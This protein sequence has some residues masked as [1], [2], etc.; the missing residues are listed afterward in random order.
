[1]NFITPWL[2]AIAAAIAIPSLI[3]LYF[4]KLRRRDLEVSTTLLWKKAVQDL[5]ANAPFQRLRRNILLF[6]QLLVLAAV[7]FALA[8]PMIK[9][10]ALS[11]ERFVILIDRSASMSSEDVEGPGGAAA[12]K[13]S[14]LD[15]AKRQAIA[16]VDSLKEGDALFGQ[17]RGD[18]AK[19]IVFDNTA[20]SLQ[21][22]TNDKRKLKDV[23]ESI[24]PTDKVSSIADEQRSGIVEAVRLALADLPRRKVSDAVTDPDGNVLGNETISVEGLYESTVAM[25][26]FSDGKLLGSSQAR[27]GIE[28]SVEY[29]AIG[30][31]AAKNLAIITLKAERD[32]EQPT[33]VTIFVGLQ[34]TDEQPR[35]VD[36]ELL[37]DGVTAQ[38]QPAQMP[39][40]SVSQGA[41][42]SEAAR[43]GAITNQQSEQVVA[44]RIRRP[45]T[46]GVTFRLDRSQG[47][48]AQVRLRQPGTGERP[49]DDAL[50]VDDR[51]WLVV[52]PAQRMSVAI[53]GR[54]NLFL[55]LALEGLPLARFDRFSVTEFE[56][57][58][59]QGRAGAYDV[60]ILDGPIPNVGQQIIATS[61]PSPAGP[62]A[63]PGAAGSTPTA[64]AGTGTN[65][66]A[67]AQRPLPPG[68]YLVFGTVPAG[69][70]L[71]DK[72]LM[73][74]PATVIDW[75]REHPAT[76]NL[77]LDSLQIAQFREVLVDPASGVTKI[78][79][80]ERGPAILEVAKAD[81][82]AIIVPFDYMESTWP[83]DLSF[84]VFV[85]STVKYLGEEV[86]GQ[87]DARAL[88][89]GGELQDTLPIGV[90]EARIDGPGELRATVRPAADGAIVYRIP[91][92]TGVYE[93]TWE[94]A[95]APGDVREGGGE[96]GR[97]LRIF[98]ANLLDQQ[99]SDVPTAQQLE[100]A[101][102]VE[103]AA[104]SAT[105]KG[106]RRLWP[107]LILLGL[108]VV[109]L[110]WFIY[111][112]KVY[113]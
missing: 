26:I 4:L 65:T 44:T 105:G 62:P 32:Y 36:V 83:L 86:G 49:A 95:A 70:G 110:E 27:P 24:Q 43:A 74:Q 75:S 58:W 76:R 19:V 93:V 12:P 67:G 113:V 100:L 80:A 14:R 41:D 89:P 91:P 21:T 57:L 66:P 87:Y 17:S 54:E 90:T 34:N 72:G 48:L 35:T 29:H 51:A 16:L 107:Y 84:V 20:E 94:G 78:A 15:E 42:P 50:R 56:Q 25:H 101:T 8:Q 18:Q 63:S 60:V 98:A 111:N 109:L 97:V 108:A 61:T 31:T 45:G 9:G 3:I 104:A 92:A 96:S 77:V 13:V 64:P 53:V 88:A 5:Q 71:T 39:A 68:K 22:F 11:G 47:M 85:A 28:N 1:M 38:I 99:E 81:T 23:I 30:D 6:L 2:A 103:Q 79:Y 55:R 73:G 69:L 106:D 7:L 102:K 52:P 37:I 46:S 40:A 82:R 10:Q 33:K 112:R 59:Q